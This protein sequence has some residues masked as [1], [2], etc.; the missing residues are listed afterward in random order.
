MVIVEKTGILIEND[1]CCLEGRPSEKMG[2]SPLI[3]LI[4]HLEEE[5]NYCTGEGLNGS[6][7][8]DSNS[9]S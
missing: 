5:K 6:A 1:L 3:D 8:C 7:S 9:P 2:L 4:R